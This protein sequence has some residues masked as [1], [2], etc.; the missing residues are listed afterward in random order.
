MVNSAAMAEPLSDVNGVTSG[1]YIA[2]IAVLLIYVHTQRPVS[3][4]AFAMLGL[5][6][7]GQA[8]LADVL[9]ILERRERECRLDAERRAR[10]KAEKNRLVN[11]G[12]TCPPRR[13]GTPPHAPT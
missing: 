3:K 1:F 11:R 7:G 2:V 13:A 12:G 9:P 4:Y 5:V 10:K 6:A 8:T